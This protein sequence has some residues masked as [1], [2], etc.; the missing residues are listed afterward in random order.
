[1]KACLLAM[2]TLAP[3]SAGAFDIAFPVDC[4][5]GTDCFIQ[6]YVDHD[7]G[8][9]AVDYTCGPLSYDGHDGTDIAL[10]TMLDMLEGVAVRAA[11]AGSVVNVRTHLDDVTVAGAPMLFPKDQDCGNGVVLDHGDGW[12]SQYCHMRQGRTSLRPGDLVT[13]GQVIGQVGMS[14]RTE[15]PHLHFTLRK[16]G[17]TLDP[18]APTLPPGACAAPGGAGPLWSG[19]LPYEPGGLVGIGLADRV[20]TFD[21]IKQGTPPATFLPDDAQSIVMWV[22]VFGNLAGDE[23]HMSITGPD[24][25][26][27]AK[28]EILE[29]T[30]ARAFRAIGRRL[31]ARPNWP[32]GRYR[33]QAVLMRD[34]AEFDRI[35]TVIEIP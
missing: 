6:Q 27:N 10:P 17:V 21:E 30:Q 31:A 5:L 2:L 7:S 16:N 32:A 14:G 25:P 19:P 35:S 15:F 26:F 28:T 22:H 1:M 4:Q 12:Q 11:A 18:F 9:G 33:A 3:A 13:A 29:R 23:L 34:G 8:P 20:P 24:G